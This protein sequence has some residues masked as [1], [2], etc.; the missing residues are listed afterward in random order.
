MK[1]WM[2]TRRPACA[3]PPKIWISGSGKRDRAVAGEIA[4]QRHAARGRGGVQRRPSRSR[5]M[6]LPPSRALFG[7]PSSAISAR[8]D[9][10][11]VGD[12]HAERAPRAIS[13]LTSATAR[14]TSSPPKPAAAV[15]QVDGLA[16]C[17]V[18]APAGAM[19]R[20]VAPLAS[21]HSAS[22]VGRPRES[23]T[24]RPCTPMRS[25]VMRV[26]VT[27]SGSC[28]QAARIVASRAGGAST[29][30]RARRGAPR[31]LSALVASMYSTGDLPST[32]AS[33][34]PGSS[35]AARAS[36][37]GARLPVDAAQDRPSASASKR[38]RKRVG[39]RG[40]PHGTSAADG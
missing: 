25:S 14:A 7:V 21:T 11:L 9:R 23:Q 40:H 12:V 30:R 16:A 18:E 37:A 33:N 3:P 1:S 10:R 34:R 24:R 31:S 19:A 2:S 28:A 27:R 39:R 35:A 6:A 32:R 22:T 5:S 20:P 8:V 26:I 29:S 15:A 4:P 13:P 38:R 36:S 17:R